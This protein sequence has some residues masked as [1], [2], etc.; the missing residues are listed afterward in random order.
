MLVLFYQLFTVL[1]NDQ[2]DVQKRLANG[3]MMNLNDSKP[4]E[5][6]K[7]LLQKGF[8]FSDKRD[9]DFIGKVVENG[10][11]NLPDVIDN[12]GEL[13]KSNFNVNS[14]A[15]YAQGGEVFRRRVQVE[16]ALLGFSDEDSALFQQE[17]RKPVQLPSVNSLNMGSGS[18]NGVV[19][20]GEKIPVQG[21]LVR[22]Q[23]IL[24]EDSLY[25]ENV[26]DVEQRIAVNTKGVRRVFVVDSLH[27]RQLQSLTAFARTDANG[28]FSFTG[29]PANRSFAVLPLQPGYEFGRSQGV[30]NL[31]DNE[32]FT[33]VQAPNTIKLFSNRDFSNLKKER[34]FIVR[35]PGEAA[36]WFWIIVGCFI[37]SF[38]LLHLLLSFR[39]PQAD[40][41]ILPVM[42][43]LTGLSFVTLFSLQDPLRDR[44]FS[45]ST[46]FYFEGGILGIVVLMLFNLRYFTT[47]S[48]IYRLFVFKG[49]RKAANGWPWAVV[50]MG[51]LLLT[52]IFGTGPEGS[53]VKVNLFGFQPSEIVKYLVIMFLAGFFAANEKFI[54]EYTSLN[55]RFYFFF[56]AL[57]AILTTI[58]LFLI[59][60]D[61]GPAMVC[62]FT[63][64]I[65]FSFS[66]GDFADMV[67]AVVVY[68]LSI[69]LSKNVWIGTA[70]TAATLTLYTLFKRRQLSE[71]AV[72][73]LVVIAGF[74][75]LDQIPYL[76]KLIPGPVHRLTDR[77]AIWQNAWNNEVFGGD[78]VANGI[79][80]MSSGGVTGQ[81]VGEGFAKTIPEAHTDMILPSMGEEFGW[82]GIICI[83]ILFLIYL[84]RS[85]I[86]GRQ[87]G[88]PFL[89][90][91]CAG[92]GV[93]TFVQFLL[94]AGGSTGALPLSGV[95]LPFMS[96][97]GS[98]LL[99]NMLAAG[100]LLSASHL[101]GSAVQ[102]K[103][104]TRQ[105]D[106]NLMPALVA[107]CVGIV[108]LGVNVSKYL[109]NN[110]RW[111]VEP[112]LVAD[113]SGARMFSYNPRISILMSKLQAGNLLDRK[114]LILATSHQDQINKQYDS[115]LSVGIPKENLEAFA[116]KRLDR[117]YPFGEQM[118][119]WTGDANTGVFNGSTN[120]YFAEYEHAAELRG[121]PTPTSKFQVSATR[122]KE[123][124][125]L[126]RTSTEMTVNRRDYGAIAPLLLAGINSPEVAAFKQRNRD[127]QL[128]MDAGLQTHL[129]RI[130]ATDDSVR[131]KR[132]SVVI[133]EDNTGDVLA[134]A[135]YPLPPV[136]DW[137][138]LTLT[139]G[140]LNRLPGW[141]LNSD[142]GFTYATQPGS[143][144]KLVTALAAFNKLGEKAATKTIRVL[145]QDLIRIKSAEPDEAGNISIE[146]AI[147]K[148]NNSFFIRLANEEHLQEEMGTLYLQTGMFLHGVGG[149]FYESEPNNNDQQN[150]WREL[151]RKTEFRSAKSYNPN[152]IKRTRGK[153]I[154]GMAW[155]Q[156]ELIATPAAVARV[157]SGI[158]NNGMLV[159][160]RYVLSI[161]GV[162]TPVKPGVAIAK[163][164]E[165]AAYMTDYMLKQSAGK[166]E[167]LKLNVAGKTGTPERIWKSERINDGW[168]VFFAPKAKGP[169][170]IVTCI[171]LE[172]AKGSSEAVRLAGTYVVP[173]LVER[174]YIKSFENNQNQRIAPAAPVAQVA[175]QD[176]AENNG[177]DNEALPDSQAQQL[178]V[179]KKSAGK[180]S[181]PVKPAVTVKKPDEEPGDTAQ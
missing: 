86:I 115:L 8:Y 64:I 85:F 44:F 27:H 56:F 55:K 116:Y 175:E 52:I 9:I 163:S 138:R 28:H 176:Q 13:N 140:E 3:T 160:N 147:V 23:V 96:Y 4:G 53:G 169:G 174:G 112:A 77:K 120:G 108:L 137:D 7:I 148:S 133:M 129:N 47:D 97:G 132:V 19:Q 131:I 41:L 67:G 78:Q 166:A 143:T 122:F 50:A 125:F 70:I 113:R 73:A 83:F 43:I 179:N 72:M 168:Y 89:F 164:P 5:R 12:I 150:T 54:S 165:F 119:F 158:A 152:N 6:I 130:L 144:A 104:I 178:L 141:N 80:A 102:M 91:V 156:G 145:P 87:T 114:G 58:F 88:T 123:D 68:V 14:E 84:H 46:L 36:R 157:A 75:L 82:A 94:I 107:A 110:K 124:R 42:M 90:Y 172:A 71:S 181:Q 159:P 49:N 167:R 39:F 155:G 127:V 32:E 76:D 74:L 15:A 57:F 35:T 38:W 40:Q 109:F 48:L 63:F 24:P 92:I 11:R 142:I 154:S 25:S 2:A 161:S 59:L 128:T 18:I 69:W 177:D 106:K 10:K 29:L 126:P 171:R 153:G 61:L 51:L 45:K 117:Y 60:G 1:K 121:F 17:R 33:F 135:S 22:L 79:W 66:R 20:K 98:S 31:E 111:V 30:E 103:F 65:L 151:W 37:V 118:F 100:F 170:H 173:A 134:S 139:E 136:N 146:R 26:G 62:C 105:Q 16:R 95:A 34:S 101:Q 93:S 21:V 149:Y 99:C 81:G 180:K 162:Q